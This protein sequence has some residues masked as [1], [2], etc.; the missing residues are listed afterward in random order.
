MRIAKMPYVSYDRNKK[1]Y[2]VRL[3][4]PVDMQPIL[5]A[6]PFLFKF[7]QS[8]D[9]ETANDL[10][11]EIVRGWKADI[12][13]ARM[14]V[15][16]PPLIDIERDPAPRGR[17]VEVS[18]ISY[19]VRQPG[20]PLELAGGPARL[21]SGR[22][23][24]DLLVQELPV[25]P[26]PERPK[27]PRFPFS[28]GID[29]WESNRHGALPKARQAVEGIM[30]R[31]ARYLKHSDMGRVTSDDLIR[32]KTASLLKDINPRTGKPYESKTVETHLATIR[33]MFEL[34]R[35]HDKID[36]DPAD[37]KALRHKGK[38]RPENK[39]KTF[40]DDER[41]R[42]LL[43]A[44]DAEPA[45][46]WST[47]IG[48][49]SG[50]R[51][52]E[53]FEADTRDIE[54]HSP[55]YD[56]GP[57]FHIRL[58]HRSDKM[59]LKVDEISPRPTPLH[60]AIVSEGFLNYVEWVRRTY[61]DGADG[62]LFPMLKLDT[63]GRRNDR[64]TDLVNGWLHNVVE[65]DKTFYS[66]RHTF[67]T[68]ARWPVMEEETHDAITGHSTGKVGREYGY[69]PMDKMRIGIEKIANPLAA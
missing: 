42:I 34:A 62:P 24:E 8:V 51:N 40:T 9:R 30:S 36:S 66:H 39:R 53:I 28:D 64:G 17:Y 29:L 20:A 68:M 57:V 23:G 48:H 14:R 3:K 45:I 49:F 18:K 1:R 6:K 56:G 38:T 69:Y 44:R 21:V 32:Y 16:S 7:K 43:A 4:M 55:E 19:M 13:R 11:V 50:A 27:L 12:T 22:R 60:S 65:T 59:R 37:H 47:W 61:H 5:G 35:T 26:R 31:L 67:K 41:R 54:E 33:T 10:S 15:A 63:D 46:R 58:D 52:A 2:F 25:E